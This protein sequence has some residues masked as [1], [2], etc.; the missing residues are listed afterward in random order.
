MYILKKNGI[1]LLMTMMFIIAITFSIGIGLKYTNNAQ[2]TLKKENFLLQTNV[3]LEDILN[4]LKTSKDLEQIKSEVELFIFLSQTSFIPIE[5]ANIK[6]ALELSSARSKFNPN[7][8]YDFNSTD[9]NLEKVLALKEYM[10]N[11]MVNPTYVDILLDGMGGVK[12]DNT[13]FSDIFNEKPTLYRDY[14]TSMEH[15]EEFN[16]FYTNSFYDNSLSK[17]KF[18]DIFYFTKDKDVKIDLNYASV[19]VWKMM[20]GIS[21]EEATELSSFAGSY[22]KDNPPILGADQNQILEIFNTSY[23]EPYIDVQLEIIQDTLSAKI[24]F[25]YD[26]AKRKG[27]NFHYEI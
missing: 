12:E 8:L 14:I 26:I 6:I 25:E 18:E 2:E 9:V 16:D 19:E 13:Y 17:V 1:A 22:T 23:Y 4:I 3:I 7:T 11:N 24:A 10:S 21:D 27:Y 15:L 5:Y 20:L